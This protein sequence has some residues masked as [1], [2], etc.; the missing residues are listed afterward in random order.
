MSDATTTP[1]A[2]TEDSGDWPVTYRLDRDVA[3]VNLDDGKANALTHAVIEALNAAIERASSEAKALV[4]IGRDGKFSA[5]FDL[6]VMTAGP[7]QARDLLH[8]GG[9]MALNFYL[10]PIPVVFG[11]TG[12]ALAMGGI[13]ATVPDYRVGAQ[14]N[15]KLGLNEVA[16]GMPVPRFAASVTKERLTP[17]WWIRSLQTAEILS[18]D[19]AVE[20]GYLDEVVAMDQVAARA[21]E[22]AKRL[23]ETCHPQAFKMTR[24]ILRA[25]NARRFENEL[26]E[27]LAAFVVN[28]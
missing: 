4:V 18:P 8:A 22:V 10:A 26:V 17:A 13:L 2:A 25:D 3:V 20:A 23:A 24:S 14:G 21:I 1:A 7:Q 19:L 5:G 9:M 15:Y 11:V 27:E 6:S 28:G 16:I 12:H